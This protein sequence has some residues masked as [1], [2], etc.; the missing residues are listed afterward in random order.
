MAKEIVNYEE[1]LAAMAKQATAVERASTSTIGTR[2]G[3]LTYGG[4][5][6]PGNK[7]E[8]IV[9]ASRHTNLYYEGKYDPNNI[10]NPSCYAYGE[11]EK[12]LAP[13]PSVVNPI[14]TTCA[15]CPKNE[16]GS[17]P[18]GGR[19]KA[20]KN[21]RSLALIPADT[22]PADVLVAEI[23]VL[24]LPVTSVANWSNYVNKLSTLFNRPPLGV[25][26]EVGTQPDTKS[27]FKVVFQYK[28]NVGNDMMPGLLAKVETAIPL[29]EREYS[30]NP[31]KE[32]VED[33]K[34]F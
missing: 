7:L 1:Q 21:S 24:K 23:A 10:M 17:D 3:I 30:A 32:L 29:L 14:N 31:E 4:Q 27:Q 25:V 26:T 20:C 13:H 9:L 6:I 28:S 18:G 33:N 15:G 34:K 12:T 2:A 19:G 16:W 8:C 11:D 22:A 5:P